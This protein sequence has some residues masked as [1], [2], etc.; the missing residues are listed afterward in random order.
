MPHSSHLARAAHGPSVPRRRCPHGTAQCRW[1]A[2]RPRPG[3]PAGWEGACGRHWWEW[4][5][6]DCLPP[7]QQQ[8]FAAHVLPHMAAGSPLQQP[9]YALR[10]QP[11][12]QAGRCQPQPTLSHPALAFTTGGLSIISL[13]T[14]FSSLPLP[15]H[16]VH[17]GDLV[18]QCVE[19]AVLARNASLQQ[20]R[21][22]APPLQ[23]RPRVNHRHVKP[24]ARL[25]GVAWDW[26][27]LGETSVGRGARGCRTAQMPEQRLQF[28]DRLC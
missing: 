27:F 16:L 10:R 24:L 6:G 17:L 25:A 20:R 11:P 2:P 18:G 19:V 1:T 23:Q 3:T 5:D 8:L 15:A 14:G 7:V 26:Q 9:G 13:H 28:C 12:R 22:H 21:Q 4:P